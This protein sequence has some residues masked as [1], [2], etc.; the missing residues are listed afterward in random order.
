MSIR[1]IDF[2]GMVQRT[3]DVSTVKQNEDNRPN[4]QQQVLSTQI[5]KDTDQN[6]H[7][8]NQSE[9]AQNYQKKY[10]AKEKGSNEYQQNRREKEKKEEKQSGRVILK[11][12]YGGG[13][14]ISI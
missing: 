4:L 5:Q 3:Q 11:S 8:V 9:D 6:L 1:P 2:N 12:P 14:D 7:Q 13:F 10:D